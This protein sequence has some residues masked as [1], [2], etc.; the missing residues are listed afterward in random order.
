MRN[1]TKLREDFDLSVIEKKDEH[2]FKSKFDEK[3][4][5]NSFLGDE[6]D[7][8]NFFEKAE[9][10]VNSVDSLNNNIRDLIPSPKKQAPGESMET[11]ELKFNKEL[12][13]EFPSKFLNSS[14]RGKT[15][16]SY[17]LDPENAKGSENMV[18]NDIEDDKRE[19]PHTEEIIVK[20]RKPTGL[21]FLD[22]NKLKEKIHKNIVAE[23][24]TSI[25]IIDN[26]INQSPLMDRKHTQEVFGD[27][28]FDSRKN[29]DKPS[30]S[31]QSIIHVEEKPPLNPS[32]NRVP[33]AR[34]RQQD[35]P[36][37]RCSLQEALLSKKIY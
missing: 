22:P 2:D 17:S 16:E 26:S 32:L 4:I 11:M 30:I 24:P 15:L 12:D 27:D 3:E 6:E 28:E 33:Q 1:I 14:L 10:K 34:A 23:T 29:S 7:M 36:A 5:S 19:I 25:V 20:V 8:K 31:I 9:D 13:A 35:Q 37:S 21:L 18:N